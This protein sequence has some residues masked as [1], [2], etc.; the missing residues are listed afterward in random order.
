MSTG[1]GETTFGHDEAQVLLEAGW[2]QGS[3]FLP[4]EHIRIPAHLDRDAAHLVVCTQ[5]CSL[6]SDS[7]AKDPHVEL[8]VAVPVAKY[9]AKSGP[10]TGKE[11]RRYHLPVAGATFQVLEVDINARFTVP[12]DVLLRFS[13]SA[14]RPPEDAC[15][16]FAGWIGRYYTRIAL[17][18]ELVIRLRAGVSNS[19]EEFLRAARAGSGARHHEDVHSIYV[20]WKPATELGPDAEYTVDLLV[21]CDDPAVADALEAKLGEIGLDP[22]ERARKPGLDVQC[23]I[24]ARGET[25]LSDLDGWTRLT[26]WDHF[27]G[28]GEV[29]VMPSE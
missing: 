28:L 4:N 24:Q 25:F 13:P 6:V 27:S 29:V 7:L 20:R 2:T 9:S 22:G 10:A 5:A 3:V 17:P 11:V 18:N 21:L 8:A 19:L 26:D 1:P 14:A 16:A 15:R 12:R 23:S